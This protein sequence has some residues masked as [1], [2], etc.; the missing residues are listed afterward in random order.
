MKTKNLFST[1]VRGKLRCRLRN[2]K[3]E[4]RIQMKRLV[5]IAVGGLMRRKIRKTIR[6][7]GRIWSMRIMSQNSLT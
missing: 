4:Q 3:K 1:K 7:R 5:G 2:K 6:Y